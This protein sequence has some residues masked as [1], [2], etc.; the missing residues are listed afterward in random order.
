V[1]TNTADA[2]VSLNKYLGPLIIAKT[3]DPTKPAGVAGNGKPV[4]LKFSNQ[5]ST[6]AAGAAGPFGLA[7]KLFLPVD[8]TVMGA[9]MGPLDAAG[10]A[11]DPAISLC[12][13]YSENR[14]DIHLHGGFVPWISDG[15]PHQWITPVG[16]MAPF[17]KGASFQNVPDMVTNG[18]SPC[19]ATGFPA[20]CITPSPT[21][22]IAT[23]YYP[24]Q[25]SARLMFY[26][27]HAYGIT[28]L[29]VYAGVAAG[30]L[31]YDQVEDDMIDGT[32]NSGAFSAPAAVLPNLGGVYRYGI[33]LVI[34]D[35][36]F[37]NNGNSAAIPGFAAT[38]ATPT[39][40]TSTVDPLWATYVGTGP[41]TLWYPHEYMTNENILDPSGFNPLGR[42]DYGPWMAA[43]LPARNIELPSP[44]I[45]PEAFMDTILV[46]GAPYPKQTLPPAA[47][48]F[49]VLSAGNDRMFN[50]QLYYAMDAAGNVCKAGGSPFDPTTCTEVKMVS[51]TNNPALHFCG[52]TGLPV[53]IVPDPITGLPYEG[54]PG[55][56]TPTTWPTDGRPGGV[57]HPATAGPQIIAIGNEGGLLPGVALIPAQPI[58]FEYN[59]RAVTVLD[60]TGKALLLGPAERADII[61]DFSGVPA[62]SKLILYNDM[63]APT[64]LYDVRYDL[65]TGDPD[66]RTIGGPPTTPAGFGP[67]TR[68]IMQISV[69]GAAVPFGPAGLAALQA[70]LPQAYKASQDPPIV[71]ESAYNTAFGTAYVDNYANVLTGVMNMTGAPTSVAYI[72]RAVPGIGYTTPPTV[73]FARTD[74]TT[75]P[76]N[77]EATATTCL[78]GVT[79]ITVT[80]GGTLYTSPPTVTITPA[81]GDLGIGAAAVATIS[82][83]VVTGI[84][85]TVPGCNY[86]L[87]PT[88]TLTG[89][90][91]TGATAVATVTPG[92]VGTITLTNPGTGY[93]R[94][95]LVYLVGGGGTGAIADAM[96]TGGKIMGAVAITEGFDVWYGRMNAV[97][98]TLPVPINLTA[99][100]PA[101]PGAAAYID[102]PSDLFNVGD[103]TIW[104]L[105]HIGVDSH[106]VHLHLVNFQVVNRVDWTNTIL[107]PDPNELGWKETV[108]TY[109]FT[110]L[111][112]AF[113]TKVPVL[114]FKLPTSNRLL[115][116][117]T[118]QNSTMNF[119][120]VVPVPGQV[121][122]AGIGNVPTNFGYEYVW[123]CHLLGHEENDMMRPFV[124]NPVNIPMA[125]A[126]AVAWNPTLGKFHVA[127]RRANNRIYVGTANIDGTVNNDFIQ[128]PTG[129]TTSAPAI[130]WN[131]TNSKIQLA[132]RSLNG[133][134]V[135]LA[136][137]NADGTGLSGWTPLPITTAFSPAIAW[138]PT[139]NKLQL[140]VTGLGNRIY[141]ATANFNGTSP[142]GWTQLSTGTTS[143]APAIAWNSATGNVQIATK[144]R[145]TNNIFV[146]TVSSTGT[147]IDPWFQLPTGTTAVAPAIAWNSATN[148]VE[149]V[150]KGRNTNNIF[151]A[152]MNANHSSFSGFTQV[153]G[154]VS[155]DTPAAAINPALSQLGV[156]ARNAANNIEGTIT[157]P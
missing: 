46:N 18:T 144:G 154:G 102:P 40:A 32:N 114:P 59:R 85:I 86:A 12:A 113:K 115:D 14:S 66:Q 148:Q 91:G 35:K 146:A 55:D 133:S 73:V 41:G 57:P 105:S 37:V 156:F 1:Q 30:Y 131:P 65:F 97:L 96:L 84:N 62:G 34:Q 150:T 21:D 151:K 51:A 149:L 77:V 29:N 90:A 111:I 106:A 98:G 24:N 64:P 130:A 79:A 78:N 155:L 5:L 61:V 31:L 48:R 89:G 145:T 23:H 117:T 109:P 137:M 141:V 121:A 125:S 3:F 143:A 99:P 44:T 36:S 60:T 2:T 139:T 28:R 101:V 50:L 58:N 7:G 4:R 52:S 87:V 142:S 70:A 132:H 53:S 16:E 42:W 82:G 15:T 71:P 153:A 38:G 100:I 140:A 20:A 17:K 54:T 43:G 127:I 93:I 120:L 152:T 8:T 6:S 147:I 26:H 112:V 83:G 25:Q 107:P 118:P 122:P 72:V 124:V 10:V 108:K 47:V 128:I 136:N 126:P 81:A 49:R 103:T 119:P 74:G 27:D 33:P 123:H 110:D 104:R 134:N 56:C 22:G 75:V 9:G 92:S 80:A 157:A 39:P 68:T 63:A 135:L 69:A 76:P 67:N 95:P 45:V 88:V 13:M 19:A 11:C 94:E 129:S 116:P 138:N